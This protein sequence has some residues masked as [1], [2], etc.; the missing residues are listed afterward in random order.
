MKGINLRYI[1]IIIITFLVGYYVGISKIA[2]DWN[3]FQPN[4]QVS[5]KEP[6]PSDQF[7][8][9]T[10]MWDVLEK[11]ETMYYDKSAVDANKMLDGAIAG[12]VSSLGDPYTL[13][14]PPTQN[15]NFKQTLAGQFEGIGAELGQKG[16]DVVVIAPLDG[17]PASKAGIKA[18]DIILGVDNQSIAGLDLNSIVNKIRGPKGTPVTLNVVHKGSTN[19]TVVKIVRDTITVKSLTSWTKKVSDIEGIN[20]K[21]DGLS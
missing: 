20:H 12:M 5:S 3:N 18:G 19:P 11:V 7:V 21:A 16:K 13:Y 1:I 14:L 9:T 4:V 2:F 10:R 15:T 8:D 6:P 17:S